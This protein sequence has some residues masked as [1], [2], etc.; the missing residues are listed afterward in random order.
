MQ[1][2]KYFTICN[3]SSSS[4]II[5]I[6]R[7]YC[8][9]MILLSTCHKMD[10]EA[11]FISLCSFEIFPWKIFSCLVSYWFQVSTLAQSLKSEQSPLW[12]VQYSSFSYFFFL[13]VKGISIH[14]MDRNA[15]LLLGKLWRVQDPS[16]PRL[17][18]N[19]L[20]V[21][22]QPPRTH[23]KHHSLI[24]HQTTLT[25]IKQCESCYRAEKMESF[26]SLLQEESQSERLLKNHSGNRAKAD[27]NAQTSVLFT[28]SSCHPM[29]IKSS[30][31]RIVLETSHTANHI[32]SKLWYHEN[33]QLC[34][35]GYIC[36]YTHLV[37]KVSEI[38]SES[39]CLSFT[40][41]ILPSLVT[42]LL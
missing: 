6:F 39:L 2:T 14:K 17:P 35:K 38:E 40:F 9:L 33:T 18:T 13:F 34:T 22:R 21:S 41:N 15:G 12:I 8:S 30:Q 42:T 24:S 36:T 11:F 3:D 23:M 25:H 26:L 16:S 19:L 10:C 1:P 29:K 4:C 27:K 20:R 5:Q 32:Y 37:L 28:I 31:E 7:T